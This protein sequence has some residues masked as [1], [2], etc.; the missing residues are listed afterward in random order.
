M[1]LI[2]DVDTGIDDAMALLQALHA[3]RTGS[4]EI[5]AITTVAG[6]ASIQDV[7]RNTY[8]VLESTGLQDVRDS[9]FEEK[10]RVATEHYLTWFADSRPRWLQRCHGGALRRRREIPRKRR[11]Q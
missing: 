9:T 8:R 7:V 3:H 5:L 1:K 6:N 11:L 10:E 4:A 2:I